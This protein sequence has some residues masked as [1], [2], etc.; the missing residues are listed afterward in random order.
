[1]LKDVI[2]KAGYILEDAQLRLPV[3]S[4]DAVEKVY[5][6]IENLN[7]FIN[8]EMDRIERNPNLND[9]ERRNAQREVIEQTGRKLE[10][11]KD[12]SRYSDLIQETEVEIP[13]AREKDENVIVKFLREREIRDRL[14]GMTEGQILSHFGE[15][16]FNGRNQSLLNAIINAPPGFEMLSEQ[17]LRKLRRL[18]AAA[19]TTND[20]AKPGSGR[21]ANASILEIYSLVKSELDRLRILTFAGSRAKKQPGNI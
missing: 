18:K 6:N 12:Q 11:L 20:G 14:F 1:M 15:S 21:T 2:K 5:V 4:A 10:E 13:Q 17:N 7:S 8:N 16:I 9:L 19:L 3:Q